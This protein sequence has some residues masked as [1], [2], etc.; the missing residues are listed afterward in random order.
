MTKNLRFKISKVFRL[1]ISNLHQSQLKRQRRF[2]PKRINI[3][4]L[5]TNTHQ[6]LSALIFFPMHVGQCHHSSTWVSQQHCIISNSLNLTMK[7]ILPQDSFCSV[8]QL[9]IG[10]Q[11]SQ[12]D[13]YGNQMPTR[14]TRRAARGRCTKQLTQPDASGNTCRYWVLPRTANL[15]QQTQIIP[16]SENLTTNKYMPQQAN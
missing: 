3:R 13:K 14:T 9:T 6:P 5:G 12:Y 11:A 1:Q 15:P 16:M 7:H 8:C 10:R 2:S 4:R